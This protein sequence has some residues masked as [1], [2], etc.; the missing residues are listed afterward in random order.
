MNDP[1][2]RSPMF[3]SDEERL[4]RLFREYREASFDPEP[5]VNFTPCLWQKIEKAQGVTLMFRR[6][7]RVFVTAAAALSLVLAAV[8]TIPS[9]QLAP[10]ATYVETLADHHTVDYIDAAYSDPETETI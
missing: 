1:M 2:F 7:S 8:M 9:R 4:D 5:S 10:P 3:Q 6:I